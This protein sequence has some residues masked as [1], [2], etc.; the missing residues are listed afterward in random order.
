LRTT[1]GC[2]EQLRLGSA[3]GRPPWRFQ[4]DDGTLLEGIADVAF[5]D[6]GGWT[7]VD[8][9]RTLRWRTNR[10]SSPAVALYVCAIAAATALRRQVLCCGCEPDL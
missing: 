10:T 2:D 9:R 6:N 7:V 1:A 8:F 4:L 5:D 3:G